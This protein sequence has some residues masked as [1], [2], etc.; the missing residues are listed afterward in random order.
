MD[1]NIVL[2]G[3]K[4]FSLLYKRIGLVSGEHL[5]HIAVTSIV[6][7]FSHLLCTNYAKKNY[8]VTGKFTYVLPHQ[9]DEK[10]VPWGW[11]YDI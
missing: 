11:L 9:P 2:Q 4:Y 7:Y 8:H 6:N 1:L 3:F 5:F 10:P